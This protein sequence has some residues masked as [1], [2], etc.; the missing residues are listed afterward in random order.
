MDTHVRTTGGAGA[1]LTAAALVLC[2]VG[3]SSAAPPAKAPETNVFGHRR[4][5][6][7]VLIA[8]FERMC[9][10]KPFVVRTGARFEA[11][12]RSLRRK[13]LT[14]AGLWPLPKRID[15]DARASR[16]LDHEWCTIRR[17]SYR[18][19]PNVYGSG[20]L[21]MPKRFADRPAPAVLC[22]HGHWPDGNAHP[23]VQRRCLVLARMG[24]V[25]FSPTQNHYEQTA[26][27]LSH[28]TLM[29]WNNIRALDYLQ[30]LP[31]VDGKRIGCA[32]ASGGG[33]QTQMLLAVDPRVKA[34]SI[35]GMTCDYREILAPGRAHCTCNHFPNI[36]RHT[37]EPEISAMALPTPVQ[38]LTM[39]DWTRTFERNNYPTIRR[40]Y[41]ANCLKGRTDCKYWPTRHSYD[42]PKRER[43]YWWMEKWLRG[44]D[45]GRPAAEGQVKTLPIRALRDLKA[46]APDN[47]GFAHISALYAA[48][49]RY[50]PPKIAGR[51]EWEAYRR[52]MLFALRGLLGDPLPRQGAAKSIGSEKHGGLVIE[53]VLCPS[54]GNILV[55][56]LVLRPAGQA[57]KLPAV[58]VCGGRGKA[59]ALATEGDDSPS[60]LARG[61][62]LVVLPDVRFTG[63][64]SLG[65]FAG[66]TAKLTTFKLCS[67]M[68]EGRAD[69]F[70]PA[71]RRSAMLWGRPIAGMGATDILAVVDYLATRK[72]VRQ[73]S[74]SLV[75]RGRA[76]AAGLFAAALDARIKAVDADLAWRCFADRSSPVVPFILRHGDVLQWS[77][78]LAD[79]SV[80][81]AGV[82]EAAGDPAWLKGVFRV[83]GNPKGLRLEGP[84][85]TGY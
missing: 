32:G 10:P 18:L 64:L 19:W 12:Q 33:L 80:S 72:D 50:V 43:M 82:P 7:A 56:A 73:E 21:Y 34:A 5:A 28:Q 11:H 37:D 26:L 85:P 38:Y 42:R 23:E 76:A 67:P 22:P 13:L 8:Y 58:V 40:L 1:A 61:G 78:L 77:A 9:R 29:I 84:T 41:E 20:L 47:K 44:K 4:E 25:V 71:W 53:L 52:K 74:I 17:V 48:K 63:E 39:N 27:G 69:T 57:G 81:L 70:E 55:P 3:I 46:A 83:A 51:K 35:C 6:A 16:T 62:S 2:G 45:H 75:A 14:C 15:L 49:V 65:A 24:Y 66:L 60:A 68:G 79:R 36:M 59:A 31:E 30:A 54:E